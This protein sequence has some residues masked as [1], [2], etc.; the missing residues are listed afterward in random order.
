METRGME[1]STALGSLINY[2]T[3][4]REG[5]GSSLC[6]GLPGLDKVLQPNNV[7]TVVAIPGL[8]HCTVDELAFAGPGLAVLI[9]PNHFTV[10][11]LKQPLERPGF[12][13]DNGL[14][15]ERGSWNALFHAG[16][17]W[18]LSITRKHKTQ[19]QAE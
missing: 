11:V 13:P 16:K 1:A 10:Q 2:T 6:P 19:C 3:S 5:A 18:S 7:Q 14:A 9:F 8:G 4:N 17:V 12:Q 15:S